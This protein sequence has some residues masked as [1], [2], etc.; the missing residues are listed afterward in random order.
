MTSKFQ[1]VVNCMEPANS[2]TS[3]IE[4]LHPALSEPKRPENNISGIFEASTLC[5]ITG[6]N[7][8]GPMSASNARTFHQAASTCSTRQ[9]RG[10][11]NLADRR[12]VFQVADI[13][14]DQLHHKLGAIYHIPLKYKHGIR[15]P[16]L[17]RVICSLRMELHES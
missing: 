5:Q 7:S 1:P 14:K 8:P 16:K 3:H 10:R 9:A 2:D 13:L 17:L 12:L 6:G 4:Q 11:P 15:S